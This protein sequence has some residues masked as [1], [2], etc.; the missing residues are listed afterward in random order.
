[1][2]IHSISIVYYAHIL[3]QVAGVEKESSTG[4]TSNHI[5]VAWTSHNFDFAGKRNYISYLEYTRYIPGIFKVYTKCLPVD[6]LLNP[7]AGLA[8]RLFIVQL[9]YNRASA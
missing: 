5:Q 6:K 9:P 3:H 2:S 7:V 1:M 4:S 8:P